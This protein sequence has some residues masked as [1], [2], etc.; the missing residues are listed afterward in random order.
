MG[1]GENLH[2]NI[3]KIEDQA[4]SPNIEILDGKMTSPT[5]QPELI[6]GDGGK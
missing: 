6:R 3:Q 5:R 4:A 2:G 1:C